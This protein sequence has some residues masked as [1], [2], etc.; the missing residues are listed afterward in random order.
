MR[1][2][3]AILFMVLAPLLAAAAPGR[4]GSQLGPSFA[5]PVRQDPLAQLICDDPAL[6]RADLAFVQAYLALRQQSTPDEQKELRAESVRFGQT[7]R[8][9]CGVEQ[10]GKVPAAPPSAAAVCV[11]RSYET[12]RADWLGRTHG[13]AAEEANRPLTEHMDLQRAL[14][15]LGLLPSSDTVDGVFGPDTR[16]AIASFQQAM[17][18]PVTGLLGSRDAAVLR[19]QLAGHR[20]GSL[21]AAPA[22]SPAAWEGFKGEALAVGVEPSVVL[23]GG[24]R[25]ALD[26]RNPDALATAT[27]AFM[28][29]NH[30]SDA[31]TSGDVFRNALMLLRTDVA[32]GA[33]RAV[34]GDHGGVDHCQVFASGHTDDVYGRDVAQPLFGFGIDRDTV[35]KIAWSRFNPANLP[36]LV[37]GFELGSF[38]QERLRALDGPPPGPHPAPATPRENAVLTERPAGPSAIAKAM[39][40]EDLLLDRD[41]IRASGVATVLVRG[42]LSDCGSGRSC[43]L[44][45]AAQTIPVGVSALSRNDRRHM[46]ETCAVAESSCPAIVTG[47]LRGDDRIELSAVIWE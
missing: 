30:E 11:A 6:A 18:L 32:A 4:D 14:Q 20:S 16:T 1:S 31:S 46:L 12:Q 33:I 40:V 34:Y 24:C 9:Q 19:E 10:P 15:D 3:A 7:V 39:T 25:I 36:K 44:A 8:G 21:P 28:Q 26:V 42:K 23:D 13:A 27:Q 38:A 37:S 22:P 5:C 35:S 43:I 29:R 47:Q 45:G 41:Q 17:D 2:I